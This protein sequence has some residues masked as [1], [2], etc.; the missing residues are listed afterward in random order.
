MMQCSRDNISNAST[1]AE[2]S[3]SSNSPLSSPRVVFDSDVE[4]INRFHVDDFFAF[5]DNRQRSSDC[6]YPLFLDYDGTLREFE[7]LP[8][9]ATPT[10]D[11]QELFDRMDQYGNFQVCIIS[12][13]D[14]DFLEQHFGKYRNFT[15]VA[16]HGYQVKRAGADW[17]VLGDVD[18][19]WMSLTEDIMESAAADT[20]GTF[21]EKK[22][23]ALVWHFRTAADDK[24]ALQQSEML[25]QRLETELGDYPVEVSRGNKIVEVKP[26]SSVKGRVMLKMLQ[27]MLHSQPLGRALSQEMISQMNLCLFVAE[28]YTQTSAFPLASRRHHL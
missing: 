24:E 28:D 15:L 3:I 27:E 12:G 5:G 23:S 11:L 19:S 14:A 1:Y 6:V 26:F 16:E 2:S 20:P 8:S 21:V 18:R 10:E 13:R 17:C 25:F 22:K 9:A 7:E 4:D